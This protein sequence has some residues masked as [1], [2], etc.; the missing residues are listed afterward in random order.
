MVRP[1]TRGVV[2]NATNLSSECG[3]CESAKDVD[4]IGAGDDVLTCDANGGV[5]I[6]P[7]RFP[8][9]ISGSPD[10][11]IV[12]DRP[13]GDHVIDIPEIIGGPNIDIRMNA[14]GNYVVTGVLVRDTLNS[15]SRTDAGTR[16]IT[17][18]DSTGT[19][20]QFCEGFDRVLQAETCADRGVMLP[21][22]PLGSGKMVRAAS[23]V[24]KE[25]RIDGA[26]EHTSNQGGVSMSIANLNVALPSVG[27]TTGEISTGDTFT[28]NNNSCRIMAAQIAMD[29]TMDR[30]ISSEA[31]FN[32]IQRLYINGV[33]ERETN[34]IRPNSTPYTQREGDQHQSQ[35]F[36]NIPPQS[37]IEFYSTIEVVVADAGVVPAENLVR[38][39]RVGVTA[40][41]ATR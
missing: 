27:A 36:W 26:P 1:T 38:S 11:L 21:N 23:V 32:V 22:S 37:S 35:R 15:S 33:N 12:E 29:C 30:D 34:F 3:P 13:N 18:T 6:G 39:I 8:D 25:L 9:I 31:V 17:H 19:Q 28:M 2:I 10:R 40:R 4:S 7:L 20:F 16:V 14:E 5:A 41:G 24:D